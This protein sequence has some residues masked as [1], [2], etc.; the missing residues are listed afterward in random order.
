MSG[1]PDSGVVE[2]YDYNLE[3]PRGNHH[4][5]SPFT[6]LS[7]WARGWRFGALERG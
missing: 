3:S 6:E 5:K 2:K 4:L 7:W 1:V